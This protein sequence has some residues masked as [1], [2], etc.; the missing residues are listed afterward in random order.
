MLP[1][2]LGDR[3]VTTQTREHDLKL[4]RDRPRAVPLLLAQ[5]DS[6]SIERPILRGTPDTISASALR[7]SAPIASGQ[8]QSANCQRPTRERTTRGLRARR[9][10]GRAESHHRVPPRAA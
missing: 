6:P 4:L 8:P 2:D 9:S 5:R 7:A 3:P 10:S 1:A